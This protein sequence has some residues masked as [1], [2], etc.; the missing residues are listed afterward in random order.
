M[1][2]RELCATIH[3]IT[4][5]RTRALAYRDGDTSWLDSFPLDTDERAAFERKDLA[6]LWRLGAHP[7]M[8]FHLSAIL[9]GRAHYIENVVPKIQGVPN[10]FYDYYSSRYPDEPE[11]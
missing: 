2:V 4:L 9:F 10:P 8:L 5:D 3:E 6:E 1:T 7:I 11:V